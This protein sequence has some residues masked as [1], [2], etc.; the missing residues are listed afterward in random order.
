MKI[1]C[2]LVGPVIGRLRSR[3]GMS[4]SQFVVR[5]QRHGWDISREVLAR[6]ETRRRRVA[7]FELAFIARCLKVSAS[8]LIPKIGLNQQVDD[9]IER[10]EYSKET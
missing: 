2:N 7:D 5:L 1:P 8:E 10:L 3:Q 9:L 4:Q 6:I